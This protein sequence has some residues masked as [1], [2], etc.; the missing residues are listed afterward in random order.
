MPLLFVNCT[1][2]PII[3]LYPADSKLYANIL[4]IA[5]KSSVINVSEPSTN[6]SRR[7]FNDNPL[8]CKSPRF[9]SL[10][11][12]ILL[13]VILLFS[14]IYDKLNNNSIFYFI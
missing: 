8:S 2:L 7:L 11:I 5:S 1:L 10:L 12:P 4:R 9:R 3:S 14:S 6:P 13:Y